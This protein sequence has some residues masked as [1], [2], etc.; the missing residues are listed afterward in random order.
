MFSEFVELA[1]QTAVQPGVE[2]AL[3]PAV[4]SAGSGLARGPLPRRKPQRN[5]GP[6]AR[7]AAATARRE[8]AARRAW[9]GCGGRA[10]ATAA[11]LTPDCARTPPSLKNVL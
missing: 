5:A 4:K 9:S 7:S 3:Q 8:G 10:G 11:S 6:E 2:S 1:V